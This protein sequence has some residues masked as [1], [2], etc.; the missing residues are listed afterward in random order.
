MYSAILSKI[1]LFLSIASIP[2]A[3]DLFGTKD[4]AWCFMGRKQIHKSTRTVIQK[5]QGLGMSLC[6]PG[7]KENIITFESYVGAHLSQP[8]AVI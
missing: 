7:K 2:N 5:E 1:A 8:Q 3:T 6:F 4:E